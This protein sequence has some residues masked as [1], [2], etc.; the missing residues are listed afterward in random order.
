MTMKQYI[1]EVDGSPQAPVTAPAAVAGV[2]TLDVTVPNGEHSFRVKAIDLSDNVGP[3]G[4]PIEGATTFVP[5]I[6]DIEGLVFL[7]ESDAL[8]LADG[9]PDAAWP[10]RSDNEFDAAQ[11]TS[12]NQPTFQ[13]NEINGQPCVRFDGA[14]DFLSSPAP[15][16]TK[17]FTAFAVVKVGA[18]GSYMAIMSAYDPL[19]GGATQGMEW[20]I[21]PSGNQEL[22]KQETALIGASTTALTP[23][24]WVKLI[25]TYSETGEYTFYLNGVADGTGTN[26][27]T[28][29]A[30]TETALGSI[31]LG[32]TEFWN[33]DM[34]AVGKFDSVLVGDDW[35]L[36]NDSL[37]DKYGF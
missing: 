13:T 12:G 3:Y 31:G 23:G 2:V 22:L 10:D 11:A 17:P 16:D 6:R 28:F 32:S 25:V 21:N 24:T 34:A 15:A 20:R 9:D 35:T 1:V 4:L 19:A 26:D 18:G 27:Q 8:A 14:D 29:V 33:G 7:F 36:L 30:G 37:D 5:G